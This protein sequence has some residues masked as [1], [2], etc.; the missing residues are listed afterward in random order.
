MHQYLLIILIHWSWDG[1]T[2]IGEGGKNKRVMTNSTDRCKFCD[3]ESAFEA[4]LERIA[5]LE[6]K[7]P[8]ENTHASSVLTS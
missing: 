6:S 2:G 4:G 7:T 8:P 1:V 5:E 3:D